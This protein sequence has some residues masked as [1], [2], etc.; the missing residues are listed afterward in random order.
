MKKSESGTEVP[1][2]VPLRKF[3]PTELCWTAGTKAS[4][5][6]GRVGVQERLLLGH[7]AL[8]Q[9]GDLVDAIDPVLARVPGR[10]AS[11]ELLKAV[12]GGRAGR[13]RRGRGVAGRAGVTGIDVVPDVADG[14]LEV[15]VAGYPLLV[16]GPVELAVDL[17]VGYIATAAVVVGLSS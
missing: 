6:A 5:S 7:R 1:A 16:A 8:W 10:R 15:A 4:Q 3:G 14:A 12:F 11:V 2:S 9:L 17:A 13:R